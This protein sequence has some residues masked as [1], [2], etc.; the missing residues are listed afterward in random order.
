MLRQQRVV[1]GNFICPGQADL[2][3]NALICHR[4]LIPHQVPDVQPDISQQFTSIYTYFDPRPA[5]R[6][7]RGEL[8]A[9]RTAPREGMPAGGVFI[10]VLLSWF[11]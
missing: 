7:V 3:L 2:Q 1:P 5:S 9:V 10:S 11:R 8:D 6:P 4:S